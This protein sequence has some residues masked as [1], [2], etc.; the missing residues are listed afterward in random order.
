MRLSLIITLALLIGT[1]SSPPPLLDQVLET[2]EL[3]VVTRNS[4]TS[5][6]IS[7]NGPTGPEYDL[8]QAFAEELGVMLV[9]QSVESVSEILPL[10]LSGE[11][12]MAAAG[13]SVTESRREYLNFGHPYESVDVHLIYKLGTGRPRE[14]ED[15]LDRSIEVMASTSHVDI[16]ESIQIEHPTLSW[17]E[18]ADVEAADLLTRVAM[19]EIDLTI[20]DSPDFNIQRHFYPDL[21]VA[22][23][24]HVDDPIAWAFPKGKGDSLLAIADE[25]LI[26]A[27]HEGVLARVHERY[28]GHTKKY[29]YVGTR[30][31]IRHYESRLPRYRATFEQAG[32]EWD[33]DWRLLAAIGY[34]ESHWRSQAVSP[35]GVR[36]IMMLTEATADYL[37]IDDR[38][39]P[40][41]SILGGAQ[42]FARQTERV[43][44]TVAEPDRTWMALA[45]YNVGFNHVKDAR[46]IAEWQGGDPDNWIDI[47]NALPLLAQRK[48]YSQVPYG[49][50]RGWEPVL[51][52]NNIRAYYNILKWLTE[53]EEIEEPDSD[54]SEPAD[55]EIV[56]S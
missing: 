51:Y 53:Q 41:M 47:S 49:Y 23:D 15:I 17:S 25:F 44:E 8:V 22:L 14:I 26:R 21:R 36:G 38:T 18:N 5:Y 55:G 52:V 35:T 4:P 54:P 9:I 27:D 19:G 34:Q 30:N 46:M 50:A 13:L 39:D 2:G 7:P 43:A 20:A 29:D 24:L 31:F 37:G 1:C 6:T 3:R 42:Y 32:A 10:L 33:V 48:W 56:S 11:A 16:L 28:Y 40:T 12:H 45:A